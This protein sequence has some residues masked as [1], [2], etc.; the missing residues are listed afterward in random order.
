VQHASHDFDA[1]QFIAVQC[2]GQTQRRPDMRAVGHEHRRRQRIA[3]IGLAEWQRPLR[4]A[5]GFD[6]LA[7]QFDR[8]IRFTCRGG[9]EARHRCQQQR[10]DH[11]P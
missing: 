1:I 3:G 6:A 10:R 4:A 2:G 11:L 9:D 8:R 7:E 5:A